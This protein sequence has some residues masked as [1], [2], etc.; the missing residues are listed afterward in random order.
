MCVVSIWRGLGGLT[1]VLETTE[2]GNLSRE[3]PQRGV[4]L[5]PPAELEIGQ[6]GEGR[7]CRVTRSVGFGA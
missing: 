3:G 6:R 5:L 4:I 1:G 2:E 7:V